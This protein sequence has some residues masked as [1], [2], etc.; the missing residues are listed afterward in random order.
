MLKV[1]VTAKVIKSC[2]MMMFSTISSITSSIS[3]TR[4]SRKSRSC[5]KCDKNILTCRNYKKVSK[6]I[7]RKIIATGFLHAAP[8]EAPVAGDSAGPYRSHDVDDH[9]L[10]E[11]SLTKQAGYICRSCHYKLN[12]TLAMLSLNN[13]VV[14][15]QGEPKSPMK[16]AGDG[17]FKRLSKLKDSPTTLQHRQ[18]KTRCESSSP[19]PSASP[20]AS[21]S[22]SQSSITPCST[23]DKPIGSIAAG[24]RRLQYQ[25]REKSTEVSETESCRCLT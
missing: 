4:P 23:T 21:A 20:L 18:S 22:A 11:D 16:A 13:F 14:D 17:R 3:A 12:A 19:S 9:A 10:A 25:E 8:A 15:G 6:D 2:A 1:K 5:L 7:A 24:R